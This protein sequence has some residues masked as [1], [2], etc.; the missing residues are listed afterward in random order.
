MVVK[1]KEGGFIGQILHVNIPTPSGH[2]EGIL[3]PEESEVEPHY[4]ALICHPH[5]L[6]GG[7]MHNKVVFKTAQV[8]QTL[9]LPALRFNFRGVGHSSG[10]Y[11][12]G[13]GE[14]DDVRYAL[15]FLS[16]RYPGLPVL[17]AGFS[18]GSWVGLHVACDDDRVQSMIAL[19]APA[20]FFGDEHLEGCHKP[21]LFIHGTLDEIA[22]YEITRQWFEQVPAPKVMMPVEGADHFFQNRLDEVQAMITSFMSNILQTSDI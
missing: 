20:R 5:P 9:G 7:T 13:R 16:K 3:K 18:F 19:G 14:M 2:L 1:R 8:L 6:G 12:E 15:D 4:T 21:K 22:P 11:D 17:L 10:Q